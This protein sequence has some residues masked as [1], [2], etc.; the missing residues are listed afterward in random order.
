MRQ[1]TPARVLLLC[2]ERNAQ[3]EEQYK[4]NLN[5]L[6]TFVAA[7]RLTTTAVQCTPESVQKLKLS[8]FLLYAGA[9]KEEGA[10]TTVGP[11]DD[12]PYERAARGEDRGKIREEIIA[13]ANVF[14]HDLKGW[15]EGRRKRKEQYR[16]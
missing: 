8:D 4:A 11:T 12:D 14:K 5:M 10:V 9:F 3:A 15:E 16:G 2:K 7:I 13:R 1:A 6:D